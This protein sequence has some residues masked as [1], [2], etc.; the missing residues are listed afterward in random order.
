MS[1]TTTDIEELFARDPL[2]LADPDID[3][4]VARFREMRG[5][6]N[7]GNAQAGNTKPKTEKQKQVQ[8]LASK[9]KLDLD[10]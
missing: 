1:A 10:F 2:E 4:M 8:D 7:L 5:Q 9:L 6:F 3:A